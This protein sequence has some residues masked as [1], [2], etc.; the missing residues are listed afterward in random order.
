MISDFKLSY[1][2]VIRKTAWYGN[3]NKYED[4]WNRL[5]DPDIYP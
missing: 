2:A 3:K 1:R 5:E 4:Q